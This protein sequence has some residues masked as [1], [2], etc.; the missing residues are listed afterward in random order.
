M[1]KCLLSSVSINLCRPR[2]SFGVG[3]VT[4]MVLSQWSLSSSGPLGPS[5]E[6]RVFVRSQ[7][8]FKTQT[9]Y[10]FQVKS[11]LSGSLGHNCF[12]VSILY[13]KGVISRDCSGSGWAV[14]VSSE[15]VTLF[16][17]GSFEVLLHILFTSM[18][19]Y[20]SVLITLPV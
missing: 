14:Q 10:S 19:K 16:C 7:R 4:G 17:W 15:P 6:T 11:T 13:F 1:T 8:L 18:L 5:P 9:F 20:G 3:V 12:G 2:L